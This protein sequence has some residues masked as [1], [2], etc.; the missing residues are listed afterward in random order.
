MSRRFSLV[1]AHGLTTAT[2]LLAL[3]LTGSAFG[4]AARQP[5]PVS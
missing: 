5:S 3:G 1:Q 4:A 2:I